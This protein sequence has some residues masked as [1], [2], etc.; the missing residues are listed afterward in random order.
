MK[1][2]HAILLALVAVLV[3]GAT[4]TKFERFHIKSPSDNALVVNTQQF[5]V[6]NGF[7]GVGT[8]DPQ[9]VLHVFG[10][11][12]VSSLNVLTDAAVGRRF[13][14]GPGTVNLT[15]DNTAIGT[16]NSYFRLTSD[17]AVAA[18]RTITFDD[19]TSV[20]AAG[21]PVVLEWADTDAGELLDNSANILGINRL[22]GDWRPLLG[23][24]LTLLYNGTDFVEQ[25]RSPPTGRTIQGIVTLAYTGATTNVTIDFS[26]G[27][28]FALTATKNTKFWPTNGPGT[29][30]N[31]SATVFVDMDGTGGYS[32]YK[33]DV[34]TETNYTS[35]VFTNT[36]NA[37]NTMWIT[38]DRTGTNFQFLVN[39]DFRK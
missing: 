25:G 33:D 10:S 34:T 16:T 28:I 14:T 31:Q 27:N 3:I 15:A 12:I 11:A 26:Q 38:T 39:P 37:K 18:N 35:L 32:F 2:T 1:K 6:H 5:I 36:A 7:V 13:S 29:G 8:N 4:T 20:P 24:T 22:D 9:A 19:L 17:S 30:F 23:H 21:T